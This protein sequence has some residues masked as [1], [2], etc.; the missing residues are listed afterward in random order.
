MKK[1]LLLPIALLMCFGCSKDAMT[2]KTPDMAAPQ[3]VKMA[4]QKVVI[5]VKGWDP[6]K[7]GNGDGVN[8][9]YPIVQYMDE[10]ENVKELELRNNEFKYEFVTTSST[11]YIS[12]LI[13]HGEKPYMATKA[14]TSDTFDYPDGFRILYSGTSDE[15]PGDLLIPVGEPL[16]A[17]GEGLFVV[18]TVADSYDRLGYDDF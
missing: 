17:S 3:T 11:L 8:N 2:E 5:S 4:A 9:E 13:Y 16:N 14:Y 1:L 10:N 12:N 18:V 6:K 15:V 7:W